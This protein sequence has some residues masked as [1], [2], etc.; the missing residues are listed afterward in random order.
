MKSM[1]CLYGLA[2]VVIIFACICVPSAAVDEAVVL[3]LL[4]SVDKKDIHILND[5]L[6]E[7]TQQTS[8]FLA[9]HYEDYVDSDISK[10]ALKNLSLSDPLPVF[11]PRKV[12]TSTEDSYISSLV[13]R[14][15]MFDFIAYADGIPVCM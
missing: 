13:N 7:L 1:K 6:I 10:D 15:G 2:L 12:L 8:G 3:S 14:N 4:S 11:S 9:S 5:S